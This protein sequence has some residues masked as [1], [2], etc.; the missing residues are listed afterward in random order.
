MIDSL[1]WNAHT[2]DYKTVLCNHNIA[3]PITKEVAYYA[4]ALQLGYQK[5]RQQ[6][7]LTLKHSA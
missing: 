6:N 2:T 5:V 1:L 4:D 3:D 7:V